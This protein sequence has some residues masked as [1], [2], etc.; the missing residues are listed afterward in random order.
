VRRN[1][2]GVIGAAL[3]LAVAQTEIDALDGASFAEMAREDGDVF[4][5][6]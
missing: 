3:G 2:G 5:V 4:L 6:Q 1:N